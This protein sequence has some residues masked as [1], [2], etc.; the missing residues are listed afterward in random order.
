MNVSWLRPRH[1]G[2]M[3]FQAEGALIVNEALTNKTTVPNAVEAL[4]RSFAASFERAVD[5][6]IDNL[7]TELVL[8]EKRLIEN[9]QIAEVR[10]REGYGGGGSMGWLLVM[11][12]IGI[13]I[14]RLS[15]RYSKHGTIRDEQPSRGN[16]IFL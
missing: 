2:Y 7:D 1:D 10:Y 6:M 9:P 5:G 13:V 3:A 11:L 15:W 16:G 8:F 14:G 4:N 12:L